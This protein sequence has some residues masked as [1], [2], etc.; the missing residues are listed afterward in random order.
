MAKSAKMIEAVAFSDQSIRVDEEHGVIRGVKIL[1]ADSL[2]GYSY[3]PQALNDAA[4]LY[5]GRPVF[6]DHRDPDNEASVR[7]TR[8][9][10][11]RIINPHVRG[12]AV[13]GDLEYLKEHGET[14][15]MIE[16]ANRMPNSFGLSHDATGQVEGTT[17][18]S[19]EECESVDVV[20]RPATN[21][22]LFESHQ[23]SVEMPKKTIAECLKG[24]RTA[25]AKHL[26]KL[27]EM[28]AYDG[29]GDTE[30]MADNPETPEDELQASIDALVMSVL[31]DPELDA[32][33]KLGKIRQ[34][35]NVADKLE[36]TPG[37]TGGE[38]DGEGGGEGDGGDA[39]PESVRKEIQQLKRRET[40]RDLLEDQGLRM[41]DLEPA[42]RKVLL[43]QEDEDE[44]AVLLE[45][46]A[47]RRRSER[48][49]GV[50]PAHSG[51]GASGGDYQSML[52]R[53]RTGKQQ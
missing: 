15:A 2:N 16:R 18:V 48:P 27:L 45:S 12:G 24:K 17:V 19:L 22:G 25:E 3:S 44:M 52:A 7:R 30:V 21:R 32:A 1:G 31:H 29:M 43:Q 28:D 47:P 49:H 40:L 38:G 50:R 35:L 8:D 33:A 41:S 37:D 36:E 42:Q 20:T 23:R 11:G 39:L 14:R 6:I 13:Y 53:T 4:R 51:A 9:H 10:W 26:R 5:E 46:F 34:I